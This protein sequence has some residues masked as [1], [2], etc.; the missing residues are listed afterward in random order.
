ML[1][2]TIMLT[3][4]LFNACFG[5]SQ[6]GVFPSGATQ[7]WDN[8]NKKWVPV[9]VDS[10]GKVSID[11]NVE[12]GD[13]TIEAIPSFVDSVGSATRAI[14]DTENRSVVNIGSET[15]GLLDTISENNDA[16][17]G[18][19]GSVKTISATT[20]SAVSIGDIG[21]SRTVYIYS[22]KDVNFG[23]S[24]I[25]TGL[26]APYIPG[27]APFIKFRFTSATPDFYFVGR[28]ET[29]TVQIWEADE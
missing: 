13:V 23:G 16:I 26:S 15:L 12:F 24:G 29:A 10:Q 4:M 20:S 21:T 3:L 18:F 9:K 8:V 6:T 25:V 2:K 7:G 14:V 28:S 5:F 17:G 19:V 11:G 22:D 27:G 1:K